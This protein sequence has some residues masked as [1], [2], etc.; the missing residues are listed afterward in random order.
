MDKE[1]D[2]DKELYEDDMVDDDENTDEEINDEPV[3]DTMSDAATNPLEL[4]DKT[5]SPS[6]VV[7]QLHQLPKELKIAFLNDGAAREVKHASS[8]YDNFMYINKILKLQKL[9]DDKILDNRKNLYNIKTKEQLKEYLANDNRSYIYSIIEDNNL[10][11]FVLS[12]IS[13]LKPNRIE[14]DFQNIGQSI[15]QIYENYHKVNIRK[16][17]LDDT[18]M[19]S[20]IATEAVVSSGTGGNE[21]I[22]LTQIVN[23][24]RNLD[25]KKEQEEKSAPIMSKVGKF[26]NRFM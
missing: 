26:A 6:E 19:I 8:N 23:A 12:E 15:D 25:M 1:T 22:A 24:V 16:D 10:S 3:Y 18:G 9:E 17:Y 13:N 5:L 7:E 14:Y 21:R 11:D 4:A 20:K 2:Y